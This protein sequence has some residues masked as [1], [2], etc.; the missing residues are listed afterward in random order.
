MACE[1]FF[2][3]EGEMTEAFREFNRM[4][5]VCTE[6]YAEAKVRHSVPE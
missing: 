6:C 5:V 1:E 3:R 4:A 2:I